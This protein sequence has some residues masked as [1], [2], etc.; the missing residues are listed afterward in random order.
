MK[1]HD[2]ANRLGIT[3][4]TLQ[5]YNA[6]DL[7]AI[8][9]KKIGK[10][11]GMYYRKIVNAKK[12]LN[13]RAIQE[14]NLEDPDELLTLRDKKTAIE[15]EK[16]KESLIAERMILIDK[17]MQITIEDHLNPILMQAGSIVEKYQNK[18]QIQEW[19]KLF[20]HG[21]DE[22]LEKLSENL[23]LLIKK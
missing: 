12:K 3:I 22:S 21:L 9:Y 10:G 16:I 15:I 1:Q 6:E 2:L 8:G 5:K 18:E 19:N 7:A 11:K 13:T 17:F 4:R 23:E 14:K 20:T